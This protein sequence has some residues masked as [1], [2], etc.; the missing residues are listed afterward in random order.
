MAEQVSVSARGYP[1]TTHQ[2]R[3]QWETDPN[4]ISPI[5]TSVS[6]CIDGAAVRDMGIND[7]FARSRADSLDAEAEY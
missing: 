7:D 5:N 1:M 6:S 3:A 2:K 4:G